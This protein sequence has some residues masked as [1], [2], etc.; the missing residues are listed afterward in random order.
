MPKK[1]PE[2]PILRQSTICIDG[3]DA[4]NIFVDTTSDID[5][6]RQP[7]NI[8]V[9]N[10][11]SIIESQLSIQGFDTIEKINGHEIMKGE[12]YLSIK[13]FDGSKEDILLH[14]P[15]INTCRLTSEKKSKTLQLEDFRKEV[16]KLW[17]D[18]FYHS[19]ALK[20]EANE[21]N[22]LITTPFPKSQSLLTEL[23]ASLRNLKP[24]GITK[25]LIYC[26]CIF[27]ILV[28]GLN[29]YEKSLKV[30]AQYN[31]NKAVDPS[32]LVSEHDEILNKA[33]A[34]M[35]IDRSKISNDLSC[36]SEE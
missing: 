7:K 20:S 19:F 3:V 31:A 18:A 28:M 33:F 36:F 16:N 30:K 27:A 13:R 6:N 10:S 8:S 34:D 2:T 21:V 26:F 15:H 35:G 32:M 23:L 22:K 25:I 14:S 1:N 17:Q 12:I 9:R 11:N 29:L 5:L 4:I 24:K